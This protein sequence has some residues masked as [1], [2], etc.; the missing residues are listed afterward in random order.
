METALAILIAVVIVWLYYRAKRRARKARWQPPAQ[1]GVRQLHRP[2]DMPTARWE[3]ILTTWS[4]AGWH[5]V[6]NN[7][8]VNTV[9]LEK[10]EEK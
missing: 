7:P 2:L 8:L 4:K 9:T 10:K 1:P 6:A 3:A 5:V